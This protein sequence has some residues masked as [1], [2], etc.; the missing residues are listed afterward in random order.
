MR[1]LGKTDLLVSEVGLGADCFTLGKAQIYRT[2]KFDLRVSS[3]FTFSL[4]EIL[5]YECNHILIR[6]LVFLYRY[7]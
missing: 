7:V 6:I 4:P 1:I 3:L 5:P 2:R